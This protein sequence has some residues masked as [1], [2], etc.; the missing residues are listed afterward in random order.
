M[1]RLLFGVVPLR[2]LI[3]LFALGMFVAVLAGGVYYGLE[4]LWRDYDD[5]D[6]GM[7]VGMAVVYTITF[8]NGLAKHFV[9]RKER[10]RG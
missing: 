7:W 3:V 1:T 4:R 9:T 5:H 10:S 8:G 6:R 2:N